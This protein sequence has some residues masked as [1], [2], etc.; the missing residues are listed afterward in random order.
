M[1]SFA[2]LAFAVILATAALAQHHTFAANPDASEVKITLNTTHEVV[3]G[4]FHIQSGSIEFDRSASHIS[5][6]VIVAAGSGKTGNDSRDKK[7]NKDILKVDEYA[8]VSFAPKTYTGTIASSGDSTIQVS[9]VFTLLGIP[10]DLTIP[11]QIHMDGS[12]ATARAHFII[13]YVQWGLKNPS[14]M[15]WKAEND[16][17]I[18]LNLVGQI[19]N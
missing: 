10:H 13:P 12:K 11:M 19:S 2:V 7:M 6:I 8:T 16:V 18:D 17:A 4:T 14:F 5:G 3:N 15:F 9:G 1:K